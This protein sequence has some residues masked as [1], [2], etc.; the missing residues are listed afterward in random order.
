MDVNNHQRLPRST[1]HQTRDCKG[2]RK[3]NNSLKVVYISSPMKVKTS[4]SRFRSLVQKLTGKNSDISHYM[5]EPSNS[6]GFID[7][8]EIDCDANQSLAKQTS[9]DQCHLLSSISA[10]DTPTSS[11][12]LFEPIDNV[13][14]S[15]MDEQFSGFFSS[16]SFFDASQLD[17]LGSYDELL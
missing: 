12:S 16:N 14:A 6:Y 15:Q 17:V 11:D 5:A 10:E 13:F 7:F 4:A 3:N 1:K 2:K 8:C 9:D